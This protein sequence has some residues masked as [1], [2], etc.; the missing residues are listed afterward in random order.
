MV[1]FKKKK[2]IFLKKKSHPGGNCHSTPLRDPSRPRGRRPCSPEARP[3]DPV[4]HRLP[5]GWTLAGTS[6]DPSAQH[7]EPGPRPQARR[8]PGLAAGADT[9]R[10]RHR[11]SESPAGASLPARPQVPAPPSRC[12]RTF[13]HRPAAP[14]PTHPGSD[15]SRARSTPGRWRACYYWPTTAANEMTDTGSRS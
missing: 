15:W 1:L 10:L 7:Q 12:S 6:R 8:E 11:L 2:I 13:P 14:R 3:G 9:G 5:R 4:R